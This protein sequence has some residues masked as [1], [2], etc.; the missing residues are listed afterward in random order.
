LTERLRLSSGRSSE[1][2]RAERSIDRFGRRVTSRHGCAQHRRKSR[3]TLTV[4]NHETD[5]THDNVASTLSTPAADLST[6]RTEPVAFSQHISQPPFVPLVNL[7][8]AREEIKGAGIAVLVRDLR[9]LPHLFHNDEL[10]A[11]DFLN[12]IVPR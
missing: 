9:G 1:T 3:N 2:R 4:D 11:I 12:H 5:P 7:D 10:V 8:D 6:L